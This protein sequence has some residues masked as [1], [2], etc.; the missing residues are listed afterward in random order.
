M[1]GV[2]AKSQSKPIKLFEDALNLK[3][4]AQTSS[5]RSTATC[6]F[7]STTSSSRRTRA[8]ARKAKLQ[9]Q[10]AM[11]EGEFLEREMLVRKRREEELRLR[12]RQRRE[13]GFQLQSQMEE[14]DIMQRKRLLQ[15]QVELDCAETE[16]D[17]YEESSVRGTANNCEQEEGE[18]ARSPEQ[19][20]SV[21]TAE[22]AIL[23]E[24]SAANVYPSTEPGPSGKQSSSKF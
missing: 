9:I 5:K 15:L 16:R 6:S 21:V 18:C 10:M 23:A 13:D 11:K 4:I 2:V 24:S 22:G 20:K 12:E 3:E 7:T 8:A 19:M 17:A 14:L 1:E